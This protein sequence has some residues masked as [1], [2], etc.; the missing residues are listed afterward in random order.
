MEDI[1]IKFLLEQFLYLSFVSRNVAIGSEIEPLKPV[2]FEVMN[3]VEASSGTSPIQGYMFGFAYDLYK[4]IPQIKQLAIQCHVLHQRSTSILFNI[5]LRKIQTWKPPPLAELVEN[6]TLKLAALMYQKALLI[7]LECAIHGPYPPDKRLLD[8][9]AVY[10]EDFF[11]LSVMLPPT[12]HEWTTMTWPTT[13]VGS[14]L[15]DPAK[16]KIFEDAAFK[17]VHCMYAT[18][19][20]MKIMRWVWE[21]DTAFGPYGIA[22]IMKMKRVCLS[23]G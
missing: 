10:V 14:C 4:L 19:S 12:S 7:Y 2:L 1:S 6:T 15:V 21:D 8:Q 16:Q 18:V 5:L 3:L 13:I 23:V 9:V 20:S 17:L 11:D 22:Q